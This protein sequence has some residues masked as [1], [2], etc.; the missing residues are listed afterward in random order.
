MRKKFS[1]QSLA[2]LYGY[3]DLNYLPSIRIIWE[4]A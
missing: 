4:Q 3:K 2:M 1:L